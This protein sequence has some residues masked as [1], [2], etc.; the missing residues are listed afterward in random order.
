MSLVRQTKILCNSLAV[1]RVRSTTYGNPYNLY[2]SYCSLLSL[3]LFV[4]NN[5]SNRIVKRKKYLICCCNNKKLFEDKIKH[6]FRKDYSVGA[7]W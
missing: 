5:C 2:R 4:S 3:S 1:R 6:P 7:Y